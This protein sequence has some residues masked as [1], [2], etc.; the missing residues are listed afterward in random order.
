MPAKTK[1][2]KWASHYHRCK[3]CGGF[4]G[5]EAS[6]PDECAANIAHA[7]KEDCGLGV[8]ELA[9]S[10]R[11]FTVRQSLYQMAESLAD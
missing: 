2:S 1:T 6:S 7:E 4:F 11:H 8:R 3:R 10:A 5:C 9:F